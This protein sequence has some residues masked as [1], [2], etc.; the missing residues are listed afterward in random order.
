M[1]ENRKAGFLTQISL[2]LEPVVEAERYI[3]QCTR[4]SS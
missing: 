1:L 3:F 2:T 4:L